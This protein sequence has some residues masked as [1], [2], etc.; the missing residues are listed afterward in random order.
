MK[1]KDLFSKQAKD[2]ATFR[3]HYPP[4]I[5]AYLAQIAPAKELAWDCATGNGQG[6]IGLAE[7][8]RNVIATDASAQQIAHAEKSRRVTYRV[9]PAEESGIDSHSVDLILVAQA[10]HWF[11]LDS[12]FVEAR[13][14]L[15]AG[16]VL[17]T[18]SYNLLEIAPEIDTMLSKFYH[19][20]TG[21]F[22]PAERVLIETNYEGIV[23]PFP[24]LRRREFQM[25]ANWNL[26]EL[27]GY[28]RTWS[29]TQKFI[30]ARGFDPVDELAREVEVIWKDP[31][32][33]REVRWPLYLRAS[34][35]SNEK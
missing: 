12:F 20:T 24:K 5:F 26:A 33:K 2:Y 4:E 16:G 25:R 27:L 29:A 35:N 13:R 17:A 21:P 3:P 6:A 22:W 10:L 18:T 19:E 31:A 28:L 30:G 11:E 15:R 32:I 9:A 1:F 34:R 14:V 23:F 7:H 8:F